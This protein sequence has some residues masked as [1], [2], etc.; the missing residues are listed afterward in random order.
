MKHTRHFTQRAQQ[1]GVRKRHMEIFNNY[2]DVECSAGSGKTSVSFGNCGIAKM[3]KDGIP[4]KDIDLVKR[5]Y[6]VHSSTNF[7]TVFK[8]Q[9]KSVKRYRRNINRRQYF[10]IERSTSRTAKRRYL[11][12]SR[13]VFPTG[14]QKWWTS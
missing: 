13:K 2:A 3:I 11:E 8:N 14:R 1:R 12:W 9:L 5:M 7:I 10:R 4:A 6:V